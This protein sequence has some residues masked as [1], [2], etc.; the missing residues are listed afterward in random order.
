MAAQ[1][2]EEIDYTAYDAVELDR[3]QRAEQAY[4]LKQIDLEK[5]RQQKVEEDNLVK[6]VLETIPSDI[7]GPACVDKGDYFFIEKIDVIS[8]KAAL[9][10]RVAKAICQVCPIIE[11]CLE[12]SFEADN[13]KGIWGGLTEK[14]RRKLKYVS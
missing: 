9:K 1:S 12:L 3:I 7:R 8:G 14:E 6:S 4:E 11:E 5:S 10:T 2:F 13:S